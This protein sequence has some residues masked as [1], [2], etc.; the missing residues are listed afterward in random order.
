MERPFPAYKGDDPYIFVCYAHDDAALVY[1]EIVRLREQGFNVWYDE[2][3]SPGQTWRDEVALALT[4]CSLFLYFVTPRSVA[5]PNCLKE[6]NFCL[7]RERKILPVH[8][9]S[10]RLPAG[11][12]LSLSDRQAIVRGDHSEGAYRTKLSNALTARNLVAGSRPDQRTLAVEACGKIRQPD[13]EWRFFEYVQ[14][15]E[16]LIAAGF[17]HAACEYYE[18]YLDRTTHDLSATWIQARY[19]SLLIQLGR[20]DKAIAL[21]T[22]LRIEH[23]LGLAMVYSRTGQYEKAEQILA[24]AREL[25]ES[26]SPSS[27]TTIGGENWKRRRPTPFAI[28]SSRAR[29]IRSILGAFSAQ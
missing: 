20:Y 23:D 27:T 14:L 29:P 1:S 28:T 8:L 10:T 24:K 12:E 6:V 15:G 4:Q 17:N 11:L 9:E 3:I 2:G 18:Y 26:V 5:S 19:R 7:S 13:P 21:M 16:C 25:P 22:E